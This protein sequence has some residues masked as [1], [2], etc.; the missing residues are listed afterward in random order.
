MKKEALLLLVL[1]GF[2]FSS[3]TGL[4]QNV[5]VEFTYDDCGNRIQRSLQ[6]KKVEENGKNIE[7]ET[8]FLSSI[9]ED[10]GVLSIGLYPNPTEDKIIV[11][12]SEDTI[13]N[14]EAILST[15]SGVVIERFRFSGAQQE[16]DLSS[17]PAGVYLL[18]LILDNETHTWKIVKR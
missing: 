2:L 15:I 3:L 8:K 4:A 14:V 18:K 10:L 1:V 7:D 6:M 11:T 17:Q 12:I 9:S 13:E 5:M 16:V